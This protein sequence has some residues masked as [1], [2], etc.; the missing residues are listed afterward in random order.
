MNML[1]VDK[2]FPL[3]ATVTL[4]DGS[5][6][7]VVPAR[8]HPSAAECRAAAYGSALFLVPS[9]VMVAVETARGVEAYSPSTVKVEKVGIPRGKL[10]NVIVQAAVDAGVSHIELQKLVLV[11]LHTKRIAVKSFH[12]PDGVGC[13]LTQAG[14]CRPYRCGPLLPQLEVFYRNYD[15][16][17]KEAGFLGTVE[18]A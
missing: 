17:M 13:P 6:G 12:T 1:Q 15:K 14:L 4:F 2:E 5:T 3:G 8:Q 10:I 11:A 9:T 16:A 7:T 18:V